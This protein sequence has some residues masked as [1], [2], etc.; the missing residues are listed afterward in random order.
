MGTDRPLESSPCFPLVTG[1][2]APLRML[3]TG[4]RAASRGPMSVRSTPPAG[5]PLL[6]AC[7]L[8]VLLAFAGCAQGVGGAASVTRTPSVGGTAD[9]S[10]TWYG[11]GTTGAQGGPSRPIV[12]FLDLTQNGSQLSGTGENCDVINSGYGQFPFDV[13]GTINGSVGAITWT[14]ADPSLVVRDIVV[15]VSG[16]QLTLSYNGSIGLYG[17]T[18]QRGAHSSYLALCHTTFP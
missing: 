7:L 10:G 6:I 5:T 2:A 1:P 12:T 11:Q 17:S 8:L 18:L 14:P 16:G 13:T 4:R 9:V 15:Q 3:A